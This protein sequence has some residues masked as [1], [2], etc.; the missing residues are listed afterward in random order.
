[1]IQVIQTGFLTFFSN[2]VF[3]NSNNKCQL[4]TVGIYKG[5][6]GLYL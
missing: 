1:M 4:K 2:S 5:L 6:K 3:I